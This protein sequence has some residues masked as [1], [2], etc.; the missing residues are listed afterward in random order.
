ML[1]YCNFSLL[2]FVSA[3][4]LLSLPTASESSADSNVDDYSSF[5]KFFDGLSFFPRII[6]PIADKFVK[7][8]N[9]LIKQAEEMIQRMKSKTSIFMNLPKFR[10]LITKILN[11]FIYM[12]VEKLDPNDMKI[13]LTKG[14][15][16]VDN[17]FLT[18]TI[19]KDR[20]VAMNLEFGYVKRIVLRFSFWKAAKNF[21]SMKPEAFRA[22]LRWEAEGVVLI[23]V[24]NPNV[25]DSTEREPPIAPS[26]ARDF[27]RELVHHSE[28]SAK[29][30]VVRFEKILPNFDRSITLTADF[31]RFVL[32]STWQN[33]RD[34]IGK[35]DEDFVKVFFRSA[36]VDNLSV[37]KQDDAV[38]YTQTEEYKRNDREEW[39]VIANGLL[40]VVI[41]EV[42]TQEQRYEE[43]ESDLAPPVQG[44]VIA[45][46]APLDE[47]SPNPK[48]NFAVRSANLEL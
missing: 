34:E 6:R 24:K 35:I 27:F 48:K 15:I 25:Y 41:Y 22:N 30:I 42:R 21:F 18:K 29:Q 1:R 28:V 11:K 45:Q 43:I 23:F 26:K 5:S 9:S 13:S 31:V 10:T 19:T 36:A 32:N 44:C 8:K 46:N 17:V 12:F 37:R 40:K 33:Y 39:L 20:N 3:C 2:F 16:E 7:K 14:R 4:T 38:I 47:P